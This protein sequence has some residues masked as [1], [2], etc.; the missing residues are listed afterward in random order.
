M[1]TRRA[2]RLGLIL[3]ALGVVYG[4]IGTSPLYALRAALTQTPGVAPVPG[5]ILGVLSLVVWALILVVTVKYITVMMRADNRGEGGILALMALATR[6]LPEGRIKRA[7]VL[8]GILG[9]SLFFGE[10][11][12]TPAIS[13]LAAIEGLNVVD[14]T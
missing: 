6:S 2:P 7:A 14:P 9:A 10:C 11:T 4:D 1:S 12:I 8:V 5:D 13:V 3:A